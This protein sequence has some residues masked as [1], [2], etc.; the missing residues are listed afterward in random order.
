M[1]KVVLPNPGG[2]TIRAR[3][4]NAAVSKRSISLARLTSRALSGGIAS[5][6]LSRAGRTPDLTELQLIAIELMNG[7]SITNYFDTVMGAH[8][9]AEAHF[10]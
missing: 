2:A 4:G 6:V 1:A 8:D 9:I 3:G 10:Y 5:F 7:S